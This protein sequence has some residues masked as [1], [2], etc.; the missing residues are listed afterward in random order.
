MIDD[1][2]LRN[3]GYLRNDGCFSLMVVRVADV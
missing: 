3:G 2:C 1:G